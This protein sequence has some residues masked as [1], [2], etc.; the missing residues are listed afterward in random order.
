VEG[1]VLVQNTPSSMR[2]RTTLSGTPSSQ[3]IRGMKI[4]LGLKNPKIIFEA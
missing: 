1:A 2:I 3:A 4:L